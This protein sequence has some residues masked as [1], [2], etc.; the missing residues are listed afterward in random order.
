MD[1][2]KITK[3]LGDM[4]V[5]D[6]LAKKYWASE[7]TFFCG[8]KGEC[9]ID[10]MQFTPVN[11]ST[12]GIERGTFSAYEVKSC[13]ADYNSKNGHNMIMDKNYYV[14]PMKVYKDLALDE[15]L[16]FGNIG[17]YCPIPNRRDIYE[18]FEDPTDLHCM[19]PRHMTMKCVN[20]AHGK[21]RDISTSMALFCMLRS[22]K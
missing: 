6:V 13:V 21:D 9:R 1:R 20:A 12:S 4:L 11:Q 10:F 5:R 22:G 14:M 18:E 16:K 19:D 2:K 15:K 8:R 17:V 7:V 3:M